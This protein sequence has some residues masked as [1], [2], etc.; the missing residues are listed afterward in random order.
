MGTQLQELR[1]KVVLRLE[2]A[3]G[4]A[5]LASEEGIND[6]CR[7]IAMVEDFEDLTVLDITNAATVVSQRDYVIGTDWTL[8]RLKALLTLRYMDEE[9]SRKL[10]YVPISMMDD[11]IPYPEQNGTDRPKWYI[12]R[13]KTVSLFPI[14]DAA[15]PIYT[16]HTQWPI[17]LSADSDECSFPEE[18]DHVVVGLG[19][20][21]AKAILNRE[22]DGTNWLERAKGYLGMAVSSN[23]TKPDRLLVAQPFCSSESALSGEYWNNPFVKKA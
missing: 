3:D 12:Q 10:I 21:I 9:N 5:I 2:R 14:P 15:K 18:I 17:T 6:A 11:R 20:D 19:T 23:S 13:G 22:K 4:R 16:T 7:L 1:R 8:V